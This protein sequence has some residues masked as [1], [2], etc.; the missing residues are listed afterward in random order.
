MKTQLESMKH[1]YLFDC[2]RNDQ[3]HGEV[4]LGV[5]AESREFA[6]DAALKEIRLARKNVDIDIVA[7]R[8]V[9]IA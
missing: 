1:L 8:K 2:C 5:M 7:F 6:L 3:E 9:I 4:V